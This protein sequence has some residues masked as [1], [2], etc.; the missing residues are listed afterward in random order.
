MVSMNE[1]AEQ[2]IRESESR[3]R[4]IDELMD[5]ARQVAEREAAPSETAALLAQIQRDRDRLARDL[6]ALRHLPQ[7]AGQ[8]LV[9]RSEGLK[10]LLQ[11]LGAQLQRVLTAV[12]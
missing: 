11:N 5:K 8:D 6:E 1:L 2:H 9:Q 3:L 12:F 7:G 4:H 10:G